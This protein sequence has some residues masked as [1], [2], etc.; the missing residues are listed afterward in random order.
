MVEAK[1][2]YAIQRFS[3]QQLKRNII[4]ADRVPSAFVR[5][6]L[7]RG[8]GSET[9]AQRTVVRRN[10]STPLYESLFYFNDIHVAEGELASCVLQFSVYD[11]GRLGPHMLVGAIDMDLESVYQLPNHE[12]WRQWVTVLEPRGKREGP[13]GMLRLCVTVLAKGDKPPDHAGDAADDDDEE[14]AGGVELGD[15]GDL[16]GLDLSALGGP[17]AKHPGGTVPFGIRCQAFAAVDLPRMDWGPGSSVQP[18]VQLSAGSKASRTRRK[19]GANPQWR[20]EMSLTLQLPPDGS[21]APPIRITLLDANLTSAD[22]PIASMKFS[23]AELRRNNEYYKK[24]RW[25]PLYGAPRETDAEFSMRSGAKLARRMNNGY[26]EGSDYRGALFMSMEAGEERLITPAKRRGLPMPDMAP[27]VNLILLAEVL[28]VDMV[29]PEERGMGAEIAVE[30]SFGL[31]SSWTKMWYEAKSMRPAGGD[32]FVNMGE[33]LAPFNAL[34]NQPIEG[35]DA[36]RSAPDVFVNIWWSGGSSSKKRR[37]AFGRVPLELLLPPVET[38]YPE[39]A[40]EASTGG[41]VSFQRWLPLQADALGVRKGSS[42][43]RAARPQGAVLVRLQLT[44]K[45]NGA[46]YILGVT[47]VEEAA[48]RAEEE[49]KLA[50]EMAKEA[51]EEEESDD[52]EAAKAEAERK[53]LAGPGFFEPGGTFGAAPDPELIQTVATRPF[54]LRVYIYQAQGIPVADADGG[55]DPFCLVRCGRSVSKTQVCAGTTSPAW[56]AEVPLEVQLPVC[57]RPDMM[58]FG[59]MVHNA[60]HVDRARRQLAAQL[61]CRALARIAAATAPGAASTGGEKVDL[62]P[63]ADPEGTVGGGIQ[64]EGFADAY[65]TQR[66]DGDDDVSSDEEAAAAAGTGDAAFVPDGAVLGWAVPNIFVTVYDRSALGDEPL[67]VAAVPGSRLFHPKY[68]DGATDADGQIF[69]SVKLRWYPMRAFEFKDAR[70]N[71]DPSKSG[72]QILVAYTLEG[73]MDSIAAALEKEAFAKRDAAKKA[74]VPSTYAPP[75]A[76]LTGGKHAGDGAPDIKAIMNVE[77]QPAEIEILLLGVRNMAPLL[78]LPLVAPAVE[79]ELMGVLPLV[80]GKTVARSKHSSRPTGS[81]ANHRGELLHVRG[82]FPTEEQCAAGL[83]VRVRDKR[84]G[85]TP[86]VGTATLTPLP[87]RSGPGPSAAELEAENDAWAF[88]RKPDR[89]EGYRSKTPSM[90]SLLS[91]L[92]GTDDGTGHKRPPGAPP[93]D[94]QSHGDDGGFDPH[95]MGETPAYLKGRKILAHELE[96]VLGYPP[97]FTVPV[98]RAA[99]HGAHGSTADDT[100]EAGYVKFCI[101]KVPLVAASVPGR[102]TKKDAEEQG[103]YTRMDHLSPDP[104][105]EPMRD[106][107]AGNSEKFVVRVYVL[108]GLE[109]RPMGADGLA[110]PYLTAQ[111]GAKTLGNRAEAI[112][113]T[114]YPPFYRTFEFKPA[115]PGA[116]LLTLRVNHAIETPLPGQKDPVIGETTIDLEDRWFNEEWQKMRA[117]PPLERRPVLLRR[118]GAAQGRLELFVEILSSADAGGPPLN[119]TPPPP[120]SVELRLVIWSARNME[121]KKVI[122]AQNDLFFRALLQGTDRMGRPV[123]MDK[124]T[125]I[126]WFSSGGTGSFNYRIV[127]RFELPLANPK[128]KISAWNKDI[129]GTT[130]DTIGE[131]TIPLGEMC[132]RLIKQMRAL[133][134]GGDKNPAVELLEPVP[135][136][137]NG[138]KKW[139]SIFHPS[140]KKVRKGEI[141]LQYSLLSARRADQRPV[142][143][144]QD[145][146]NRDPVLPRPDRATLDLLNPFASLVTLIGPERLK[147]FILMGVFILVVRPRARVGAASARSVGPPPPRGGVRQQAGGGRAAGGPPLAWFCALRPRPPPADTPLSPFLR[148]RAAGCRAP[149]SWRRHSWWP[150]TSSRLR[151]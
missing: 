123:L 45:P 17:A 120:E 16:G 52:D 8:D 131:L 46:V 113:G 100:M 139:M 146:P 111:L 36:G 122:L 150:M 10:T 65:V 101:R 77:T 79:F 60:K 59:A 26:V 48:K 37:V 128:L 144:G 132:G 86:I 70:L 33:K 2:V 102:V 107:V 66:F 114:L 117:M 58:S 87:Q 54:K 119:I 31:A 44:R 68:S 55:S 67:C 76:P 38:D 41:V 125:D 124:A 25:Y 140:Q 105:L 97:F 24:P 4:S 40:P 61:H 136:A 121:N 1:G 73:P 106:A 137:M 21:G 51:G 91:L 71:V 129:V 12:L 98:L 83:T 151:S 141:E 142:G 138:G 95:G 92:S 90:R 147:Q 14:G 116:S 84:L 62:L 42:T 69:R 56:F 148:A 23:Y 135:D 7:L 53:R 126:H 22:V 28:Q 30:V 96:D 108:R 103:L 78:G 143:E 88:M 112:K 93:G 110:S 57:S 3:L 43:V 64:E 134:A 5:V 9:K 6:K 118:G 32:I 104:P 89:P 99:A 85:T 80:N 115:L 149:S 63:L 35:P 127:Y 50:K 20:Q 11:R 39:E 13:Q 75:C 19:R 82:A 145:E 15:L 34:V 74:V 109:L 49:K 94:P 18:Y 29:L 72:G 130:D 133:R 47:D 27:P 81:N